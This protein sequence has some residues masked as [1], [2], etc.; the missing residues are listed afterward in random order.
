MRLNVNRNG[1]P[2]L[3]WLNSKLNVLSSVFGILVGAVAGTL[4]ALL[5]GGVLMDGFMDPIFFVFIVAFVFLFVESF[6][7]GLGAE[8]Y[9]ESLVNS[10]FLVLIYLTIGMVGLMAT[11]TGGMMALSAISQV[12][13]DTGGDM[14]GAAEPMGLAPEPTYAPADYLQLI[15]GILMVISLIL[16]AF[17]GGLLAVYIRRRLNTGCSTP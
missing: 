6:V 12:F 15:S 4:T 7:A 5:L 14:T 3:K 10:G 17:V 2:L 8:T 13:P 1:E 9:S 16:A 11:T